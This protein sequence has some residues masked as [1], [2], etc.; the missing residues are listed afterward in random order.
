MQSVIE[1]GRVIRDRKTIPIKYPLKEI[2]VIHQDPEALKDIK[3]LEKYIIEEVKEVGK[4]QPRLEA[5]YPA[6]TT[7]NRYPHVLPYDHSRVRLTQL[8]G[9]PHSDYINANFIPGHTRPPTG[10]H[11]LSG[12]S[13]ENAG[14][15][16]AAGAGVAGPHHH[17]ADNQHGEREG[18]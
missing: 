15:L 14:E 18:T 12:A 8:E 9:E 13:Q 2:V 7:K 5:E 3:S 4:E 10:I 1:L 17:H 16:L 6:N 11:C